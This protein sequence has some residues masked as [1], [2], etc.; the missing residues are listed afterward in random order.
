MCTCLH[1]KSFWASMPLFN[2]LNCEKYIYVSP[3]RVSIN[4]ISRSTFG[5]LSDSGPKR[6]LWHNVLFPNAWMPILN[7]L[8]LLCNCKNNISSDANY[9][10]TQS[11]LACFKLCLNSEVASF[12]S[13]DRLCH[14]VTTR[15]SHFKGSFK[16]RQEMFPSFSGQWLTKGGSFTAKAIPR[17]FVCLCLCIPHRPCPSKDV[18]AEL[19]N[20][21]KKR[22]LVLNK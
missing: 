13:C 19:R 21:C 9:C 1:K 5:W 15:P 2:S 18:A 20:S 8:L 17:F 14:S 10:S 3:K 11:H 22:F 6:D 7:L 4:T 12:E 16:W